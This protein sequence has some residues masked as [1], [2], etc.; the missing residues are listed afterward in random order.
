MSA[1]I[2][3]NGYGKQD[4]EYYHVTNVLDSLKQKLGG[5]DGMIVMC[6]MCNFYDVVV[7]TKKRINSVKCRRCHAEQVWRMDG[8][9]IKVKVKGVGIFYAN[10]EG[11]T[12]RNTV[13]D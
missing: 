5:G 9:H 4:G 1:N 11:F 2:K 3:K 8:S 7:N 6:P 12:R 10:E 13:Y